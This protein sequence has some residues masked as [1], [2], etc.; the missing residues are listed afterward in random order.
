ME[1]FY[2]SVHVCGSSAMSDSLTRSGQRIFR[3]PTPHVEVA[4]AY[5]RAGGLERRRGLDRADSIIE[6]AKL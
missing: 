2:T 4:I 6:L 1:K 3:E 5:S